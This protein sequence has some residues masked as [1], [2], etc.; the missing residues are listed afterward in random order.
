MHIFHR[1]E[2]EEEKWRILRNVLI[3]GFRDVTQRRF[4]FI[5]VSEQRPRG[6]PEL[7]AV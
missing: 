5:D 4:V 6:C 7:Y 3:S 2:E 1:E